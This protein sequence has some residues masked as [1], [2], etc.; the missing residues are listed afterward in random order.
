MEL[1]YLW[2]SDFNLPNTFNTETFNLVDDFNLRF[3][4]KFLFTDCLEFQLTNT[5][6]ILIYCVHR[7]SI[8]IY[9]H[10]INLPTVQI[11]LPVDD[12][13]MKNLTRTFNLPIAQVGKLKFWYLVNSNVLFNRFKCVFWQLLLSK[14]K[15]F[16]K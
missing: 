12:I 5:I 14:W 11:N 9:Q 15:W 10:N 2:K 1:N 6:S 4:S 3:T 7:L 16:G 13:V 8:S